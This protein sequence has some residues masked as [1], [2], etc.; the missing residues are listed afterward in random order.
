MLKRNKSNIIVFLLFYGVTLLVCVAM[1]FPRNVGN[2]LQIDSA[3]NNTYIA[4]DVVSQIGC[5]LSDDGQYNILA[6]DPQFIIPLQ[7]CKIKCVKLIVNTKSDRAIDFEIYTSISNCEFSA[8]RCYKGAIFA[9]KQSAVVN[10]P[11]GIYSH[12]RID[13]NTDDIIFKS[14]ETFDR[15]PKSIPL[16][17]QRST[18]DYIVTIVFP[19]IVAAAAAFINKKLKGF[20]RAIE[21]IKANKFTIITILVYAVLALLVSFLAEILIKLVMSDA[22][23]NL[24]R[25]LLIAAVSEIIVVFALGYKCLRD[26]PENLFLPIVLILGMVMVFGSPIKHI[27]WDF[28]SHYPWAVQASYPGTT[29]ATEAYHAIDNVAPQSLVLSN[30]DMKEDLKYLA[31][32][33]EV[34][35]SQIKS[36][37][38]LAH[39]PSGVFIAVSRW[40]GAGFQ[41]EYNM[42]RMAYLLVYAF[43]CYFAI[44]KIKSGKMILATICLFPTNLFLSTNY[45]Y[46]WCVTAFCILGT[47]YFIS[48]IQQPDKPISI[49]DTVIMGIA[50][51]LGAIPKL[52]YI[53]LMGM[54]LFMRKNWT[55]KQER[56]KYYIIICIIFATIMLMFMLRA[57]SSISGSGDARGGAVNPPEQLAGILSDPIGYVKMLFGF[58]L[59]YLSI[60]NMQQYI[61]NFAYLGIGSGWVIFALCLGFTA[62]TD[63]DGKTVYNIPIYMKLLSILLYVGMAM[64]IASALYISFTPVGIKTINGCQA[65]YITPLLAPLALLVTGKRFNIIKNKTIYNGCVLALLSIGVLQD[66]YS[67]IIKIMI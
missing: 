4:S 39:L 1:F 6:S 51:A 45:A 54:T 35:V 63:T 31:D 46:D 29:Y 50:F 64:L 66:T 30:S 40:L 17:P 47:S 58:L 62:I 9:G 15:Q 23:F 18:A 49:K 5:E 41:T 20:E 27:C 26:K 10:I 28:D 16:I 55:S 52:I 61:S 38:S 14:V 21:T 36:E 2:V 43:V 19:I 7:D 3:A 24:Y 25:W 44:K 11:E 53:V 42:G 8:E 65:R 32:G 48:E 13:I 56:R 37:F 59:D 22:T 34:V 67:Q 12:L 57:Q 33:D 60:G